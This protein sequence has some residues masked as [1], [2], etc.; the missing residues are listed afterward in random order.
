MI[1]SD[2]SMDVGDQKPEKGEH[3]KEEENTKLLVDCC[4]QAGPPAFRMV[5]FKQELK[6]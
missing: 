5:R 1:I 2:N 3:V 4:I 6:R